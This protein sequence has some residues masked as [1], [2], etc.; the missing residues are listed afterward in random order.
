MSCKTELKRKITWL[1]LENPPD[2]LM[3]EQQ[4]GIKIQRCQRVGGG[5]CIFRYILYIYIFIYLHNHI[6]IYGLFRF[7]IALLFV[8]YVS[9]KK[10]C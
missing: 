3:G 2:E 1:L 7:L 6:Y 8:S 10:I 9:L 5:E 4:F